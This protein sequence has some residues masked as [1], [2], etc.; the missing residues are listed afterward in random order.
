MSTFPRTQWTFV[1]QPDHE[2]AARLAKELNF[3]I[4][5][6]MLLIQR[7]IHSRTQ[8]EAFFNPSLDNLHDPFAMR[9]MDKAVARIQ[10]ALGEG[11]KILVYGDYDVDGTTAVALVYS[12][13]RDLGAQ[14]GFYIP[15]RYKEGY[16]I[17]FAGIDHAATHNF[18]LIIALDCGIKSHDKV[19]YANEKNIDFIICDHHRPGDT[20]PAA[21][22]VL[23]PKRNDCT[24]PYDELSGCGI[25]F[26]LVQ[27]LHQ[28][29]DG[30]F[31]EIIPYLDLVAV[32]IAADIVPVTGE[33]RILATFG[34]KQ[35]NANPR[36][37]FKALFKVAGL[38]KEVTISDLVFTAA[39]RINAAGRVHH[40][41]GAV[42][43]LISQ[44]AERAEETAL[45]VNKNNLDRR[46]FDKTITSHAI[47][48]ITD[49]AR[50]AQRKSTVVY[51]P[52]WHKGVV[53]IVASRL[54]ERWY[55]PTI[56]LTGNDGKVTGSARSVRDFDVYEAI[57]ACS[58]L[59][60]QFGGHK[61]AAGLTLKPE[62]LD[63][64]IAKFDAEVS[65]RITEAQ[66]IPVTEIDLE[67][68]LDKINDNFFSILKKFA[69]FGPGNMNPVFF[70]RNLADRGW[71][72][73]VGDNHLKCDLMQPPNRNHF[74][75]GIGFGMGE[76]LADMQR[77]TGFAACY[78]LEENQWNGRVS[79][80]MA[81]KDIKA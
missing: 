11:E 41:S 72:R 9:D 44:D 64:F 57:E 62:N 25:G 36:P 37:A 49:D 6:A 35:I 70:T 42:E 56:V 59:L 14:C 12:Y 58:D 39:P 26:K 80:Q 17:S 53:G 66:L 73:V 51:H 74:F 21:V 2:E 27:A 77:N 78:T 65:L 75:G 19:N 33:N 63:A 1:A 68:S 8:A 13:L 28:S 54:I 69:P 30:N 29:S 4:E 79:I 5:S 67:I 15:D 45:A 52:E 71:A 43:L 31:A 61:Y 34:L 47:Q 18:S 81:L 24:Y 60:I 46:D 32:S 76:F 16:G 55:R 3:P 20:I 23:D 7:G 38:K 10:R 22:A 40:G 50:Y 48:I